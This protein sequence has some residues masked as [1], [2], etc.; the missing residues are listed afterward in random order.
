MNAEQLRHLALAGTVSFPATFPRLAEISL[1][2]NHN[3][4]DCENSQS[5]VLL[6]ATE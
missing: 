1:S 4:L 5:P 2:R 6:V 3:R